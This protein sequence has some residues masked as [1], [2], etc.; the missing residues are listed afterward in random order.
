MSAP[1]ASGARDHPRIRGEHLLARGGPGRP[2]GSSPHTRGAR[3][4]LRFDPYWDWD[5]PRIRGEHARMRGFRVFARGSSPHTRGAPRLWISRSRPRGII[6][7]YAGST[8]GAGRCRSST[9]DHPRIRGEHCDAE[10]MLREFF[11]SSPHTRG[12]LT[13]GDHVGVGPGIIPAYAGSTQASTSL[14]TVAT[15]HPR[16]RGEH[17]LA[18]IRPGDLVGSSPHT[19]G[20]PRPRR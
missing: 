17:Q 16:I 15:D 14:R 4:S 7:A 18:L 10:L 11:G 6:P 19:R 8:L 13:L 1:R 9:A 20:A 2:A 3:A 12:A 5:H